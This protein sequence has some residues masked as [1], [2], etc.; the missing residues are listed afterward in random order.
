M[1]WGVKKADELGLPA[2]IEA[3]DHGLELYKACGFKVKGD[4]DLDA[5]AKN[6]SEEFN[7][8]RQK[9]GLPIHG[10]SMPYSVLYLNPLQK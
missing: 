10:V 7:Q 3:S 5:T 4:V 1:E 6:P 9:L 2:Y 8:I